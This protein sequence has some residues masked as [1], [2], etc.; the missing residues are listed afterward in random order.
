MARLA[1]YSIFVVIFSLFVP[2]HVV[3]QSPGQVQLDITARDHYTRAALDSVALAIYFDGMLLDS[4]VTGPDG[5]ALMNFAVSLLDTPGEMPSG[6][7]LSS[8][9]PNPFHNETRV[10]MGVPESQPVRIEIFNILGQRVASQSLQLDAGRYA[11][12]LTMGHL[13]VGVYF[14]RVAGRDAKVEKM[15]KM[16]RSFSSPGPVFRMEP[17]G[18]GSPGRPVIDRKAGSDYMLSSEEGYLLR[19][20]RD[21]YQNFETSPEIEGNPAGLLVE[22]R[23]NNIVSLVTVDPGEEPVSRQVRITGEQVA[24]TINTPDTLT[25]AS[26]IYTVVST[27]DSLFAVNDVFEIVSRDSAYVIRPFIPSEAEISGRVASDQLEFVSGAQVR[28]Y[29]DGSEYASTVTD[30]DGH[31]STTLLADGGM[32]SL[33]IY[34]PAANGHFDPLTHSGFS[35]DA[36]VITP[37]PGGSYELS[38]LL[39][40]EPALALPGGG[41]DLPTGNYTLATDGGTVMVAN[42]PPDLGIVGGTARAYSPTLTPDAFPGE[43]A[44]RQ[45]G[46][47]SGLVSGGFASVNLLRSD[48]AGGVEPISELRD[49]NGNRVEVELRFR[50]DPADY[51][52]IRDPATLSDL[53]GFINRTDTIDV[54]LYYY[55]EELGDWR[56]TPQ[57]GW[58]ENERG[59]IPMSELQAIQE[60]TYQGVLYM[61]GVV[62]HFTF[63]NLDFPTRD[64][65]VTGRILD[66]N[67]QPVANATLTISSMPGS[68]VNSFFSNIIKPVS[69]PGGYFQARVPRTETGPSDDWNNNNRTDFYRFRAVYEDKIACAISI[70]DED[71]TGYMTPFFPEESGCRNLGNLRVSLKE[72]KRVNFNIR[73]LDIEREGQPDYPLFVSEPS[74]TGFN[75]A[76]ATLLDNR[77]P[78]MGDVWKCICESETAFQICN[79]Q[80]TTDA[81]GRAQFSLPVLESDPDLPLNI[82]EMLTG[83]FSYRKQRP[84]LGFGAY[85]FASCGYLVPEN[86]RNRTIRCEVERRG[87]PIVEITRIA[88]DAGFDE[89][90]PFE[91]TYLYDDIVIIEAEGTD[92]NE[93]PVHIFYWTNPQETS[94]L[95]S[96]RR[97]ATQAWRLFGTGGNQGIMAHGIDFYGWRNTDVMS[98]FS[99]EEVEIEVVASRD[100]IVPG[101]TTQMLSDITGANNTSVIWS[102]NNPQLASINSS[103]VFTALA[104]G[105]AIVTGRSIIDPTKTDQAQVEIANLVA[106]FTVDPPAGDSTTVFTFD[107]TMSV[108]DITSY[109]W[110]FGDGS[111]AQGDSVQH[112]FASSE[113]FTVQLTITGPGGIT[114]GSQKQV[115]ANGQP[116]A[117]ISANVNSGNVPLTV[118]FDGSGSY[119]V[120]GSITAWSW[121]FGDDNIGE[122]EQV[123]HTYSDPGTFYAKLAVTDSQGRTGTDSVQIQV[124]TGPVASFTVS[125]DI[126]EPPLQVTVDA[127]ETEGEIVRYSW[128]F[129]DGTIV[130]DGLPV[131]NHTYL[132]AGI[133]TITLEVED[134]SGAVDKATR[135]VS[136]SCDNLVSGNFNISS[137]QHL[138]QITGVCGID[139]SLSVSQS[140][141]ENLDGLSGLSIVTGDVNIESNANLI[142]IDGMS[143]LL[144]AGR[145]RIS[146]NPLLAEIS[147]FSTTVITE[148]INIWNNRALK[149]V[150]GFNAVTSLNG[151]VFIG[152]NDSLEVIDGFLH[153]ESVNRMQLNQ[154]RVMHTFSAF[155]N[156][157][158][159]QGD[160]SIRDLDALTEITA[161]SGLQQVGRIFIDRNQNLVNINFLDNITSV[162]GDITVSQNPSL[163]DI[164]SFNNLIVAGRNIEIDGSPLLTQW[165][166]FRQLERIERDLRVTNTGISHCELAEF[167][168]VI[169]SREGIGRNEFLFNNVNSL[170]QNVFVNTQTQLDALQGI[171]MINGNLTI[172]GSSF[173]DL[174]G[175]DSLRTVTG[176][177]G[178][179]S[180]PDLI[181]L[182]GLD[183]MLG[184]SGITLQ[185]NEQLSDIGALSRI[186][187]LDG[188]NLGLLPLTDLTGL[189]ALA[190]LGGLTLSSLPGMTDLNGLER[191]RSLNSL[192]I[193]NM[194]NLTSL[195]GLQQ[196][197]EVLLNIEFFNLPSLTSVVTFS[198]LKKVYGITLGNV[199]NLTDLTLFEALE[200]VTGNPNSSGGV[201]RLSDMPVLESLNGLANVEMLGFLIINNAPV[202]QS[203]QGFERLTELSSL[204]LTNLGQLTTLQGIDVIPAIGEISLRQIPGITD[205]TGLTGLT[206]LNQIRLENNAAFNSF[207]GLSANIANDIR[208]EVTNSPSLTNLQ[209]LEW[210]ESA[211][212]IRL[213]NNPALASLD[214]LDNL[215]QITGD[216]LILHNNPELE[217]IVALSNLETLGGSFS[218]LSLDGNTKLASLEPLSGLDSESVTS[219]GINRNH[220][221]KDLSG[222]EF[223]I[224]T[225]NVSVSQNDSLLSLKGLNNLRNVNSLSVSFNPAL[226]HMDDLSELF[227]VEGSLTI[228]NNNVL[229]RISGMTSLFRVLSTLN[230]SRN[231]QLPSCDVQ[232]LVNQVQNRGGY[233]SLNIFDND[234]EG[235]CPA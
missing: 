60:G 10:D 192:S 85:E 97:V 22:M 62:D 186:R 66:Q 67:S 189:S 146:Q 194:G 43:F 71:G 200:V 47:E 108:G 17:L 64:A 154:N 139:G 24:L 227:N 35:P 183:N 135:S 23:R 14:L 224:D 88:T 131:E 193:N 217:S 226:L 171:C 101:D 196:L 3:A 148:E 18:A 156:L 19:A 39:Y 144:K 12:N 5:R 91:M 198:A 157:T 235:T 151:A 45:Q 117:S 102:V 152:N 82:T 104:P 229:T 233:G 74:M 163:T 21:R 36:R 124:F 116:V 123:E 26:G 16:G 147:G 160:L 69:N 31:F 214:G 100:L 72:A 33:V 90:D 48:G 46:V 187:R 213:F 51:N 89:E 169:K 55:D 25:L 114:A 132:T 130:A 96:G 63:Y 37:H 52:V 99:V 38:F 109:D 234:D 32:Y 150:S 185:S 215:K 34:P 137:A 98:G 50:I 133:R 87:P 61:V 172:S 115:P 107:A 83:N 9:Y 159:I 121:D 75:Y 167:A 77:I 166:G 199:A 122:G 182:K 209:G 216:G 4:T 195:N 232:A 128:D 106:V 27:T 119:A 206:M 212:A 57:F 230:I 41:T 180:N 220:S 65:C 162:T 177:I 58:L 203:L 53:P 191:I 222:L 84:D 110:D 173:I 1:L 105:V 86:Q 95:A 211:A 76:F 120:G 140:D 225:G 202:L 178:I 210:M 143:N 7:T 141:L 153:L 221:L 79:Y 204:N 113:V 44:T 231:W 175:L 127:S 188:L 56:L 174:T 158:T 70:F 205:L 228:A 81:T 28:V 8:N 6:F 176:G 208:L 94:L 54:P 181:S 155:E 20:W 129:G 142:D 184:V 201:I 164:N 2:V 80:A 49:S 138:N 197:E 13:P 125:P 190:E 11:L 218:A 15:V 30:A 165:N 170:N 73:F 223:L 149:S 29:R 134:I 136:V 40:T 59:A 42:I 92:L 179:T 161:L 207:S 111:T 78:L 219:V 168:E 93:N 112:M 145:I 126:G 103:G 118:I 68:P